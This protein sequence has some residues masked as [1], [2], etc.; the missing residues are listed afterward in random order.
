MAFRVR[1]PLESIQLHRL[2]FHNNPDDEHLSLPCPA[3][4]G[5]LEWP[6]TINVGPTFLPSHQTMSATACNFK[7]QPREI[8]SVMTG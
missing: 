2:A 4:V 7:S 6:L 8:T 1:L 3:H 5:T